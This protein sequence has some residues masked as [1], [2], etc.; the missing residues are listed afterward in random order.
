MALRDATPHGLGSPAAG[1][2]RATRA[3]AVGTV[4]GAGTAGV[5]TIFQSLSPT[6]NPSGW[7]TLLVAG[8]GFFAGY[9]GNRFRVIGE[10]EATL[11][12][13]LRSW[14]LNKVRA[15]DPYELGVFPPPPDEGSSS[16][17]YVARSIDADLRA[18][19]TSESER[20]VIVFGEENA[21]KSRTLFEAAKRA[22]GGRDGGVG[23]GGD[24]GDEG[25]P[26]GGSDPAEASIEPHGSDPS[27]VNDQPV[28]V[29]PDSAEALGELL[30]LEPPLPRSGR[31]LLWLDGLDR[32]LGVLSGNALD[33]I[34][35]EDPALTLVATIRETDYKE[36]LGRTDEASQVARYLLRA[37]R[38]FRL[39]STL[40]AE[41]L[42]EAEALYPDAD[43]SKPIG[44]ALGPE[45]TAGFLPNSESDDGATARRWARG[46]DWQFTL[47]LFLATV[48]AGT[49]GLLALVGEFQKDKPPS[50]SKQLAGIKS[51]MTKDASGKRVRDTDLVQR[52]DLRGSGED[53]YF[54]V[55]S[56]YD[57][58][59]NR[60]SGRRA[61]RSDTVQIYDIEDGKLG[62]PTFVYQPRDPD[63][64][65]QFR[66]AADLNGDLSKEI[67]G[68]WVRASTD[69]EARAAQGAFRQFPVVITL[70]EQGRGGEKPFAGEEDESYRQDP[71]LQKAPSLDIPADP[72]RRGRQALKLYGEQATLRAKDERPLR[73]WTAEDAALSS[74]ESGGALLLAGFVAS[75]DKISAPKQFQLQAF[76]FTYSES[77]RLNARCQIRDDQG[78]KPLFVVPDSALS[79]K[80][81]L[82]KQW[83]KVRGRAVC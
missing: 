43:F 34:A 63:Y 21:G 81:L 51:K 3:L 78:E 48:C 58:A 79:V 13:L 70:G 30:A 36:A 68:A 33:Q 38:G 56:D 2:R 15:T 82:T 77:F 62:K 35:N 72:G 61:A 74:S 52:V 55:F 45:W 6:L 23:S 66:G 19:L 47:C 27:D 25:D 57:Q 4:A 14:P 28:L 5:T 46:R 29:L 20:F 60:I 50:V 22:F 67:V 24:E 76:P 40:Q 80:A 54:L 37:G 73:G 1:R 83:K 7:V 8:F 53:S 44:E 18:A 11:H 42:A 9:A 69:E 16:R 17:P 64:T 39:P 41:E 31:A 12:R 65:F 71:L 75:A 32:Y 59:D 10:R 49:V 26:A